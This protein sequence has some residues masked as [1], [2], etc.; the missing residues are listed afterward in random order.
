[1]CVRLASVEVSCVELEY[2]EKGVEVEEMVCQK[3]KWRELG[4]GCPGLGTL[5]PSLPKLSIF[6]HPHFLSMG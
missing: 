3:V 1:M 5:P 6:I 4:M 2:I